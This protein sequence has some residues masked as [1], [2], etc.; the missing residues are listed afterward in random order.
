MPP[1]EDYY[2]FEF[3]NLDLPYCVL[4]S[5]KFQIPVGFVHKSDRFLQELIS[6]KFNI[7]TDINDK[8][9]ILSNFKIKN[10]KLTD[11]YLLS[12]PEIIIRQEI[13][14]EYYDD[15]KIENFEHIKMILNYRDE[16]GLIINK[17]RNPKKL[18]LFKLQIIKKIN[19]DPNYFMQISGIWKIIPNYVE[20]YL[21]KFLE[22][23]Q[24]SIYLLDHDD[25]RSVKLD[26]IQK[27]LDSAFDPFN[28]VEILP[29]DILDKL[30]SSSITINS[31]I[32]THYVVNKKYS[33]LLFL[34]NLM[35]EEDR[36]LLFKQTENLKFLTDKQKK[37][38]M[39]F[40]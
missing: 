36:L 27:E 11:K 33:I 20:E 23:R 18:E 35:S 10:L 5:F 32:I 34:K 28:L 7:L 17:I 13:T 19:Q 21:N 40:I 24:I 22:S 4:D 2:I 38:L 37:N 15:L 12:I 8:I 3:S 1:D 9:F 39:K 6:R 14:L 26:L 29:E 31:R 25:L 30:D 16:S